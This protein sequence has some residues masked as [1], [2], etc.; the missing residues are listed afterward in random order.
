VEEDAQERV[1]AVLGRAMEDV[2]ALVKGVVILLVRTPV[3]ENVR[4]AVIQNVIQLAKE[5]AK[6][7]VIQLAQVAQ[8]LHLARVEILAE[9]LAQER[10]EQ[11]AVLNVLQ[12]VQHLVEIIVVELLRHR[13]ENII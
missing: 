3:K 9:E 5:L 2:R 1:M 13:K 6:I 11:H 4:V 7:V 12:I 10:V 8:E